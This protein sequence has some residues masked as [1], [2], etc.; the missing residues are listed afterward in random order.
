MSFD[1]GKKVMEVCSVGCIA[2][3]KCEKACPNSAIQIIN[4]LSVID[5][6]KCDNRG[7]CFKVCPVNTV[8]RKVQ[9]RFWKNKT[10]TEQE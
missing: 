9:H 2:C 1:M 7:E 8:A 3:R 6:S 10:E 5:Y 4:N